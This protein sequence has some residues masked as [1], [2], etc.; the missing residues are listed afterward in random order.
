MI[1]WDPEIQTGPGERYNNL[2]I[3]PDTGGVTD[4]LVDYH[5]VGPWGYE[6]DD[7]Q[8]AWSIM[9]YHPNLLEYHVEWMMELDSGDAQGCDPSV[10]ICDVL[11]VAIGYGDPDPLIVP[12]PGYVADVYR[13]LDIHFV[14]ET[15]PKDPSEITCDRSVEITVGDN[16]TIGDRVTVYGWIY[17]AHENVDVT[18][19]YSTDGTTWNVLTKVKTD[20]GGEYAYEWS[21]PS[22]GSYSLKAEWGGDHDHL[23][24]ESPPSPPLLVLE[25]EELEYLP[26][27][28]W[29]IIITLLIFGGVVVI[30]KLREGKKPEKKLPPKLT[31]PE[32][33]PKQKKKSGS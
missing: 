12:Y 20:S 17:P 5:Y 22:G 7:V 27:W 31:E 24:A 11:R 32:K 9:W 30:K 23:G 18:L 2:L 25:E 19:Y 28:F 21:A 4:P 16:I 29:I 26:E 1:S 3:F 13:E 33:K 14:E 15:K 6:L 8:N 10:D